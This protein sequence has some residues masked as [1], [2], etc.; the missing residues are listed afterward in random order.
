VIKGIAAI[1]DVMHV[2]R[3]KG[4][5][6]EEESDVQNPK[7]ESIKISEYNL[8]HETTAYKAITGSGVSKCRKRE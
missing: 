7:D 2:V 3:Q 4:T 6:I 5:D 8:Q 1:W